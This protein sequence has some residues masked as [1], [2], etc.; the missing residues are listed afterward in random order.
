MR[1]D[2]EVQ[3]QDER[4]VIADLSAQAKAPIRLPPVDRLTERVF[5]L[6]ALAK[7]QDVQAARTTL[8][9]YFQGGAITMTPETHGEGQ[10]YTARGDF[11]PL[12]LLTDKTETPPKLVLGGRCHV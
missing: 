1:R 5:Q 3:A 4:S 9:G 8:Q 12:A 7:S 6:R 11:M 10:A 2:L